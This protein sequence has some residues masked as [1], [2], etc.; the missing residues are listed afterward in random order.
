MIGLCS[1]SYA[2]LRKEPSH[3]SELVSQI[4]FWE[5]VL[6]LEFK[7]DWIFIETEH[8]YQGFTRKAQFQTFEKEFALMVIRDYSLYIWPASGN[9]VEYKETLCLPGS[10]VND[11]L[12]FPWLFKNWVG[13]ELPKKIDHPFS[14]FP[15]EF[16]QFTNFFAGIPYV[17]G[18]K[19]KMGLDCSGLV[20]VMFQQ[21]GY[22]FPRDAWQQA[23]IGE[24]VEFDPK[25]PDFQEGDLLFFQRPG[26]KI[27]HVAISL[28]GSRYFHA[29]EWTRE[30][31]LGPHSPLFVQDRLDTLV[32]AKRIKTE[33]LKPLKVSFMEMISKSS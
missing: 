18:G 9:F 4:I 22:S 16:S 25:C 27:H 10:F 15:I 29:S 30:N 31:D 13:V 7:E 17:W 32:L 11:F 6:I 23:E 8:G 33:D 14:F 24:N 2:Q 5:W 3:S 28:G 20:Q 19:T 26:K 1:V 12:G 21:F